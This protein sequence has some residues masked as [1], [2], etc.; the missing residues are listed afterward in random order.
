[1]WEWLKGKVDRYIV[2]PIKRLLT[3]V[4]SWSLWSAVI[5]M[6]IGIVIT[7]VGI[8]TAWTIAGVAVASIGVIVFIIGFL[9]FILLVICKVV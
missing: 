6:V 8:V 9:L 1:M 5:V 4:C 7:I 2:Q 3:W